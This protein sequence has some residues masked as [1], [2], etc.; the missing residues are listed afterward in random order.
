[1]VLTIAVD[2]PVGAGKSSVAD[3]VA[4]RLG[5]LHMDTGAMYRAF[6]YQALK[7]GVDSRDAQAL[8]ALA[9]REMPEVR[10]ENG[11]QRT[12]IAGQ[13]VTDLIRTPEI[14][15]AASVI[16]MVPAV[17]RAM[18]ARQRELAGHQS[19]LLDGRDIGTR[20]LPDA[21]LKIFLTA[22]PEVRAR[23]RFEELRAK[24]DP[25]T[26]EEVLRDVIQ[27]DHQDTTR[28]T[29]PLRPA[30]DA[31]ILDSSLMTRECNFIWNLGTSILSYCNCLY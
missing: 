5:I 25:S 13:D 2:G 10:F 11:A 15:M 8:E 19:M 23:R 12:L 26:Y 20:V 21:T 16:S 30:Q 14:S 24:G 1:M 6:A 22:S 31:Q 4:R 3:E 18:V 9:G 29:D 27:R 7:E 17:R 28:E